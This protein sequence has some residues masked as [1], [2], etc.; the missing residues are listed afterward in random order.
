MFYVKLAFD[1]LRKNKESYL[2]F[3]LA[4]TAA[5]ALNF[6]VQLLIYSS[7]VKNLQFASDI[8]RLLLVLGQVI[9]GLLSLVI[10][11]YTY[12]F[13]KKGKEKEFGLYSILGMKKSDL[14]KISLIQQAMSFAIT[15]VTGL[16]TGFVFAKLMILL[17]VRMVGGKTFG[18]ELSLPALVCTI[19]FFFG[20]YAV[21]T[22]IDAIAVARTN[23]LDLMKSEKKGAS[24]PKNRWIFFLLGTIALVWGYGLS[25][26]VP[27]PIKA[28]NQ[29]FVAV[30]LVAVATYLLFIAASTLIL[31]ALQKK[32][33]YYYQS[34]HFITVSNMLFRMKQN[35]VGLASIALLTTMTLV[36][37]VT[38]ASMYFG[39]AD[40]IQK[41]FP[42]DV[43]I[44]TNLD[45]K[46]GISKEQI[47]EMLAKYDLKATDSY[48]QTTTEV[49]RTS[50]SKDQHFTSTDFENKPNERNV[51]FM[52]LDEYQAIT[53]SKQTLNAN[54]VLAYGLNGAKLTKS[55]VYFGKDHYTVK[56]NLKNIKG[57]PS[58]MPDM[59]ASFVFVLPTEDSLKSVAKNFFPASLPDTL[60]Q[61]NYY[62]NLSGSAKHEE[63]FY[64]AL[65][66]Y[67][68]NYMTFQVKSMTEKVMNG[69]YGGFFFIGILFSIS[70]ILATG[71]M[72][73]YKQ[74]SEGKA[75]QAQFEILQKVGM[76][77][78]EIKKTIRSQI[79]WLFGLPIAVSL[80]HLS[81]AMPMIN[82]LLLA[83]SVPLTSAVY[84]VMVS[85]ILLM[86][87]I[88]YIIYK[89]TSRTY[90]KQVTEL[91]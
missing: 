41:T 83:F 76:S 25:L 2:P 75:D 29:F 80:I 51:Q 58:A 21:L 18:M 4:G 65:D 69:I 32:E 68:G 6:L 38:T 54:E 27:S 55:S 48:T 33:S 15:I 63:D 56:Q 5:V 78:G 39:K 84:V 3:L 35:A 77:E 14:V 81:F 89:I 57:M 44:S 30:L 85:T 53:G 16:I 12:S 88:Y 1:S 52:T 73:Y 10:M 31:K 46:D 49:A 79:I 90:F 67:Q 7:G 74:I 42:R 70:F 24:A 22:I 9:I 71:L 20:I 43:Q 8:V 28:V 50:M 36:V 45:N 40:L 37:T 23:T 86:V 82:K 19:A 61:T 87:I 60:M 47:N 59:T 62:F 13:L 72:I 91:N 34:K 26:T 17:L 64:K 11:I 66:N